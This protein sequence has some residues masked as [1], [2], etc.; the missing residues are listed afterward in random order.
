M[1]L[2]FDKLVGR[3]LMTSWIELSPSGDGALL[4]CGS[5]TLKHAG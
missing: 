3:G 2:D 4:A 1:P 5:A